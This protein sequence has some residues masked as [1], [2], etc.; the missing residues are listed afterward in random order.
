M[1]AVENRVHP[2]L[3]FDTLA[4]VHRF[5]S[6][7]LTAG[8]VPE[9]GSPEWVELATDDPA[10]GYATTRAALAWWSARVLGPGLPADVVDRIIAEWL[11]DAG[12]AVYAADPGLWQSLARRRVQRGARS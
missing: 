6:V 10:R 4:A 5:V 9:F 11:A 12:T 7:A 2:D 8:S 3:D 1:R